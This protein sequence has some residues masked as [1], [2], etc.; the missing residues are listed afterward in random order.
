MSFTDLDEE[1]ERLGYGGGV[2][3]TGYA[4]G[5]KRATPDGYSNRPLPKHS[6]R[7]DGVREADFRRPPTRFEIRATRREERAA[8]AGR[9]DAVAPLGTGETDLD[10][11]RAQLF[12]V[13]S[14]AKNNW[15]SL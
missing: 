10:A 1:L 3:E 12:A 2:F 5:R 15:A 13:R 4:S 6:R 7:H 9:F 11:L 14:A 8:R